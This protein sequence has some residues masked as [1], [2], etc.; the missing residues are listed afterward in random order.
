MSTPE[1]PIPDTLEAAE[2][3]RLELLAEIQTIQAQLGDKARTDSNGRRL[4]SKDY[5]TWRRQ[6]QHALTQKHAH[7]R[8]LKLNIQR[9]RGSGR[10]GY[11]QVVDLLR[12]LWSIIDTRD[13][14][15]TAHEQAEVGRAADLLRD[16]DR[17]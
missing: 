5:W 4:S 3:L 11:R 7:L 1:F 2:E 9:L 17:T 6:A 10:G 14:E 16:P 8:A 12:S 13:L 15:L